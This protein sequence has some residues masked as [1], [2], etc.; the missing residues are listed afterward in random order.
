MYY[1][2]LYHCITIYHYIS[3]YWYH[4]IPLYYPEKCNLWTSASTV[5]QSENFE[6]REQL[7]AMQAEILSVREAS[8]G[9]VGKQNKR[10]P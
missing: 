4:Y 1:E 3:L 2:S 7:A 9:F 6:L 10:K 5:R 8:I